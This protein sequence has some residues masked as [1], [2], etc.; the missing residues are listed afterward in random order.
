MMSKTR[1]SRPMSSYRSALRASAVSV[2]SVI[3][4]CFPPR[5]RR[6]HLPDP[7][8]DLWGSDAECNRILGTDMAPHTPP[9]AWRARP[10]T[11]LDG[12]LGQARVVAPVPFARNRSATATCIAIPA[13]SADSF[14][15]IRGE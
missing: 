3:R 11:R 5:W 10:G 12:A 7:A 4:Y 9:N 8:T 1:P 14:T 2:C 15:R 13:G 6:V